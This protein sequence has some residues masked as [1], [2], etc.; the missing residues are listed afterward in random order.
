MKFSFIL[1]P[2]TVPRYRPGVCNHLLR[3]CSVFATDI[4]QFHIE[5]TAKI[6]VASICLKRE[7]R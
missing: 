3:Y 4:V 7:M 1:V 2:C 5:L 6:K